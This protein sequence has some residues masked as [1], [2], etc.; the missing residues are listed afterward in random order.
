MIAGGIPSKATERAARA[1]ERA[2][3]GRGGNGSQAVSGKGYDVTART[4]LRPMFQ[5]ISAMMASPDRHLDLTSLAY[6]REMCRA[7]D[8][9]GSLFSGI[10]N[11]AVANVVGP[12]FTIE[13]ATGDRLLDQQINDVMRERHHIRDG[14]PDD[15]TLRDM[16]EMTNTLSSTT[17]L[18]TN[19]LLA[20]AMISLVVG[21]V[22]IMN[23]MLVSVKERTREIGLRKALGATPRDILMQFL[24]EAVMITFLGGLAGIVL[25]GVI[26]WLIAALAQW[27]MIITLGSLFLA[28][29]FSAGVG[30]VFGLWPAK[31]AAALDP[32]QALRYE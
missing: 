31:Q 18:M 28:F 7:H 25:A 26:S 4:R 29:I 16:T 3:K 30:I 12:N 24:V 17:R 8:R 14:Q 11:R 2:Y 1:A 5:L 9:Q 21:G 32:I 27:K 23:I 22:G 10:L 20:V 19:L 13:A 6:L 15:F